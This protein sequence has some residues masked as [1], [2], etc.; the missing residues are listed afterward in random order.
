MKTTTKRS[1]RKNRPEEERRMVYVVEEDDTVKVQL[2]YVECP[3]QVPTAYHYELTDPLGHVARCKGCKLSRDLAQFYEPDDKGGAAFAICLGCRVAEETKLRHANPFTYVARCAS[4]NAAKELTHFYKPDTQGGEIFVSC[5]D[6]RALEAMQYRAAQLYEEE[7][8]LATEAC[9]SYQ[10]PC[11]ATVLVLGREY[12][13][14][15]KQHYAWKQQHE[16]ANTGADTTPTMARKEG[17]S[18]PLPVSST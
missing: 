5:T 13:D 11:G 10:C 17:E 12:H 4:C 3:G 16:Q 6:C 14:K 7:V 15:T 2:T 8:A 1:A 9:A 18:V